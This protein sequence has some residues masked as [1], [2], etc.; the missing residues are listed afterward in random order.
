MKKFFNKM[1]TFCLWF[2]FLGSFGFAGGG[3][4]LLFA[5]VPF[6]EWLVQ[7]GLTQ[8]EIDQMLKI[9][10]V[11]WVL[12]G[13]FVSILFYIYFLRKRRKI[14][15]I[16]TIC[17]VLLAIYVYDQFMKTESALISFSQGEIEQSGERFTFGPYPDIKMLEKLKDDGYEGVITLLS[18]TLPFEN[19]LLEEEIENGQKIGLNVH[20]FPMLP[21]VGDN[22][23]SLNGIKDLITSNEGKYYIH[24]YL[25]KHRVDI[26]KQLM[27]SVTGQVFEQRASIFPSDFERGD[28]FLFQDGKIILGP[29]PTEEEWSIL[30]RNQVKEIVSLLPPESPK[31]DELYQIAEGSNIKIHAIQH[32]DLSINH[33]L[34]VKEYVLELKE[35][36]YITDFKTSLTIL[37]L[38]TMLRRKETPFMEQSLPERVKD[39]GQRIGGWGLVGPPLTEKEWG[40]LKNSGVKT[41]IY[42]STKDS[43][44]DSSLREIIDSFGFHFIQYKIKNENDYRAMYEIAKDIWMHQGSMYLFSTL[45]MKSMTE[46]LQGMYYGIDEARFESPKPVTIIERDILMG[47]TISSIEWEEFILK[48]GIQKII[49]LYAASIHGEDILKDHEEKAKTYGVSFE[50]IPLFENYREK[51]YE[52]IKL[53][54]GIKY[55]V[56]PTQMEREIEEVLTDY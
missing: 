26:V 20:S 22:T 5:V 24:C 17:M 27:T 34:E 2:L 41:V 8:P 23:D 12:F 21:W 33:L 45:D 31:L 30:I 7:K 39:I 54:M 3:Y 14:A 36:V 37:A 49:F 6:E 15:G 44:L 52:E 28:V 16:V 10:V 4:F 32:D 42:L 38:E 9:A 48:I 53:T 18:T 11:G 13:F 29:Y 55:I 19:E 46:I 47:N 40:E 56:I 51:L 35:K 25:G 1:F 43:P 50:V